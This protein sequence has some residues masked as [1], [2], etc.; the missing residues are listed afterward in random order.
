MLVLPPN[1]LRLFNPV[2]ALQAF[3]SVQW[4][5]PGWSQRIGRFEDL[6]AGAAVKRDFKRFF[7]ALL[8]RL[9]EAS[10]RAGAAP[11]SW[12]VEDAWQSPLVLARW[13]RFAQALTPTQ[14]ESLLERAAA[15]RL[16]TK[17]VLPH[18]ASEAT[19]GWNLPTQGYVPSAVRPH[20][21][22]ATP[23]AC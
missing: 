16:S 4:L 20:A 13:T 11:A 19:A 6:L 7:V 8:P 1:R 15:R 17:W 9:I 5:T 18:T 21:R 10:A 14:C 3:V 23:L 2:Q 12:A 22:V